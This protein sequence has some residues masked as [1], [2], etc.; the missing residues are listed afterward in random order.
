MAAP[1]ESAPGMRCCAGVPSGLP[2][3]KGR[4][5]Y[6]KS[7]STTV[8]AGQTESPKYGGMAFPGRQ[9]AAKVRH[10][11]RHRR[12]A[13]LTIWLLIFGDKQAP[14]S[15]VKVNEW[16]EIQLIIN[17]DSSASRSKARHARSLCAISGSGR[18]T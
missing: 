4:V 17:R 14:G 10:P 13:R 11:N 5:R 8:V 16:D 12:S 2:P 6:S 18:F 15:Y 1:T 7:L 9:N 3:G